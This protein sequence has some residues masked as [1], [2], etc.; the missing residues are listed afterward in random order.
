MQGSK[1]SLAYVWIVLF[2]PASAVSAGILAA[3]M[4]LTDPV[5]GSGGLWA[6]LWGFA[7]FWP[8]TYGVRHIPSLVLSLAVL[9]L[10]AASRRTRKPVVSLLQIRIILLILLCLI[11]ILAKIFIVVAPMDGTAKTVIPLFLYAD[12]DLFLVFLLTFLS[13]FRRPGARSERP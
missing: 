9:L 10:L 1:R 8:G 13:S 12:L 7:P 3:I 5:T 11:T 6:V 4:R 2:I